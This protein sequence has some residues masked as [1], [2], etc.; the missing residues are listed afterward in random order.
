MDIEIPSRFREIIAGNPR[1]KTATE[2]S[3]YEI[4]SLLQV[5]KLPFFPEYTDHGPRHIYEVLVTAEQLVSSKTWE[6]ALITPADVAVFVTSVALHDLAMH[7]TEDGFVRLLKFSPPSLRYFPGRSW[8]DLWQQFAKEVRSLSVSESLMTYGVSACPN[9]PDLSLDHSCWTELQR[10][11]VGEFIRRHHHRLAHEIAAFGLPGASL[12]VIVLDEGLG[13]LRNLSGLV[14]R[15][16]AMNLRDCVDALALIYGDKI[17]PFDCHAAYLMVLLRVADFLQ[18]HPERAPGMRLRVQTLRSPL[19]RREWKKHSAINYVSWNHADPESVYVSAEVLS[20]ESYLD[21]RKLLNDLQHEIDTCWAVLGEV[22]G[23]FGDSSLDRL[24]IRLRRVRT[25][26]EDKAYLESLSFIPMHASFGLGSTELLKLMIA[27][28]YGDRPEIAIRELVQ[29]ACDAVIEARYIESQSP[30]LER[31]GKEG[32]DVIVR[33]ERRPDGRDVLSV[34]DSGIGMSPEIVKD[35][36]LKA[37]ASSRTTA[38]WKSMFESEEG[39]PQIIRAGRFGV[40]ALACFLLGDEIEV[41]TRRLHSTQDSGIQFVATLDA[42]NIELK[43]SVL[44]YGTEVS[45]HLPRQVADSLRN[46]EGSWDWWCLSFPRVER[47]IDDGLLK[48]R[49]LIPGAGEVALSEWRR[50]SCPG[51]DDVAWSLG[52]RSP[53]SMV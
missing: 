22:F 35:Y 40:G 8:R 34:Q 53:E 27:P 44:S 26:L 7:I 41:R 39:R 6:N 42:E 20:S 15:S 32:G 28:L 29:N 43:K 51:Y 45:V 24:G 37:G 14:A 50:I 38:E 5:S 12:Q 21:I 30:T 16:H 19:S 2:K 13:E 25:N 11:V 1:L 18:I 3:L 17:S 49:R 48:Q 33:L 46:K 47:Y 10:R 23:R 9:P 4:A 36:F 31:E 52:P